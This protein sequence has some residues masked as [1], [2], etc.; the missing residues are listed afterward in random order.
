MGNTL[1]L[2]SLSLDILKTSWWCIWI[3]FSCQIWLVQPSHGQENKITNHLGMTFIRVESGT[4][5]MGS[6]ETE[7][8]RDPNEAQHKV[9]IKNPF[10]LQETEVTLEQWR[11]VMGKSWFIRRKGSDQTPVTRVS[12]YDVQKFIRKLNK[13][14]SAQYQ[15]RLPSEAEW[16]YACRAGTTTA[17]FW[18]NEIDCSRAMYANST[19]L[20]RCC[21]HYRSAGL[22][23]DGPAPV[24]S[25]APNPWGFYDMHGNVWEWCADVYTDD[26][27]TPGADTY[28]L[29]SSRPRVRRGGSWYKYGQFLRSA[30]RT[31]AHPGA[32]FQ[33]TGFRLVLEKK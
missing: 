13:K 19:K 15:Y 25:F 3:L 28:D 5:Q 31:Y 6:P 14:N 7:K 18:G 26:I 33:T 27:R 20:C 12:F 17:Y 30:N 24:G 29:F 8:H 32:R 16:E 10:Y 11:A 9:H 2:K 23:V 1:R 4:F 21:D 22:P